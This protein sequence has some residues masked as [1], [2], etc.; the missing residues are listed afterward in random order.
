MS[1]GRESRLG[2][3]CR[4]VPRVLTG[5]DFVQVVDPVD[6]TRLR[7]LFVIEPDDVTPPLVSPAD[8]AN[9]SNGATDVDVSITARHGSAAIE[10]TTKDWRQVTL[11]SLTR[12]CLEIVVAEPGGFEPY[13]LT[14][15]HRPSGGGPV[16][17]DPFSSSVVFDFKQACETGFDCEHHPGCPHEPGVDFP[18]DYLARDF[19]SLRRALLDFAAQRHQ[20][21]REPIVADSGVMMLEIMAALGDEF[22]YA[23]DR[24]DGET[25]FGSATQRASLFS[26]ARLV[27]YRPDVGCPASGEV[28]VSASAAGTVPAD[29]VVHAA[30]R[31]L[32]VVPFSIDVPLWVH[33]FWNSLPVHSP[34]PE[35]DCLAAGLTS[36]LVATGTPPASSTPPDPS[37]PGAGLSLPDFLGGR[38]VMLV[39]DPADAS[40]GRRAWPVTVT[41]VAQ[42]VDPLILVGGA[43]TQV[44][45][46][47]WEEVAATPFDLPIDGLT[48]AFNVA[49]VTAGEPVI[50]YAR[51]GGDD[52]IEAVHAGL[53]PLVEEKL[54]QLPRL[55]ERE[56]PY[57]GLDGTDR[58][59]IARVGLAATEPMSL[60]FDS[61]GR[62]RVTVHEIVPPAAFPSPLPSDPAEVL[63]LFGDGVEYQW[64]PDLLQLDL[65]TL[66][67]VVEP[68]MW[69]TVDTHRLPTSDFAFRDYA[70]D[71]G[72]TVKFGF[73][74]LGSSPADGTLLR[75][76]YYTDPG[77]DGNIASFTIAL[78]WPFGPKPD[79]QLSGFVSAVTNP[80]PFANAS[81]EETAGSI[82][83]NAPQHYRARPR[84]AVRPE[85][86]STIIELLPWVDRAHSTTRW[87]GSW[88]TDFVAVDPEDSVAM[89]DEQRG[90][91]AAEID[92]IRLAA[93]DARSVD[94]AYR[95]IDLEVSVCV[96]AG[97]AVGDVLER[98]RDRLAPPGF[99]APANFTFG[100]PLH[101]SAVEAA[102]QGVP[103]VAHVDALNV[104]V[105][106]VGDWRPFTEA[107]IAA[108]PDEIIRLQ[109]DP[110]HSTLGLLRVHAAG[111]M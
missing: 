104:R 35:Q 24:S 100:E 28:V 98:V 91:L 81:I 19:G 96:A 21:W 62:P 22:S 37:N 64:V 3:L 49:S 108:D 27:E 77:L 89:S 15:T 68:G 94:P 29:A 101:R 93:R 20:D 103:G 74:D 6:Q 61:V 45:R 87:T 90:E 66:G 41:S 78:S 60:R 23:Q 1:A 85:D 42:L 53:P 25:R 32:A 86:Y 82:R 48:V 2:V 52:D 95:D 8:L 9:P 109:D 106:G 88:S 67:F 105:H 14:L 107:A 75:L 43:P 40:K 57:A 92:C 111:V 31:S 4:Q 56:G 34:D 59:V 47:S 69:R 39:S 5:I 97:F 10:V 30:G 65:D 17:F 16:Q 76:R 36:I 70:S 72:W 73:G 13:V 79:P 55:V 80:L 102:V 54:L 12:I 7:I 38:R 18:V 51:A 26:H 63:S 83:L 110:N 33:P 58:T 71:A 84:R 46:L 50:E 11:D 99:F 44:L